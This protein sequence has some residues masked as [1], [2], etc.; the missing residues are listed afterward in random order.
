MQL[1]GYLKALKHYEEDPRQLVVTERLSD[2]VAVIRLNDPNHLNAMGGALTLKFRAAIEE[3]CSDVRLRA[4]ILT[5]ADPAFSCGG[6]FHL[7]Q[8]FAHPVIADG[9][10][11]AA[12]VWKYIRR[13]FGTIARS[14]YQSDK[15]FVCAINGAAA[16]VSLSFVLA[17]DI[18][19]AS[20]K[21]RLL[22]AF[23]KIGLLPEV[24]MSWFLTRR[25]GYQRAL[26]LYLSGKMLSGRE[27]FDMGLV[28]EVVSHDALLLR[29]QEWCHTI[30]S[31]PEHAVA[32]VKPLMRSA[33]DMNWT[34]SVAT[35]EFSES[36]CFSTKAHRD[37]V[38]AMLSKKK[39]SP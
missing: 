31:Q 36:V 14:I 39:G 21:A 3:V 34:D 4:V 35:E 33:A 8:S 20:E 15:I 12:G 38:A 28:N 32:M 27:A 1:T 23:S 6:D 5:G 24:G 7:M 22:T 13:Q 17:C 19:I 11:G 9:E 18:L 26:G 30:C 10:E 2:D 16:G 25:L 29:A 37:A